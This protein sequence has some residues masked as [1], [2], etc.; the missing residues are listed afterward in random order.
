MAEEE[1]QHDRYLRKNQALSRAYEMERKSRY[2]E[3]MDKGEIKA[4][5]VACYRCKKERP[6]KKYSIMETGKHEGVVSI[7]NEFVPLCDECAPRRD[8]RKTDLSQKQIK[9]MLR[10]ARRGR[11]Y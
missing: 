1:D 3:K 9:S 10:G 11:L 7:S 8:K 4:Q 6:C 5:V 2:K